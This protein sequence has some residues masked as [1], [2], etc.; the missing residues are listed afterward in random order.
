MGRPN[1]ELPLVLTWIISTCKN[2]TIE[3]RKWYDAKIKFEIVKIQNN[4]M[5][6]MT[7]VLKRMRLIKLGHFHNI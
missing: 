3:K 6:K 5:I 1:S 7:Q 2:R 4:I